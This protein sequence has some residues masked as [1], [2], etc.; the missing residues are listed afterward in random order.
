MK[1][2]SKFST[3][4]ITLMLLLLYLPILVVVL[5]SFNGNTSRTAAIRFSGFSLHWYK[6]LFHPI[7]GYGTQ[8]IT[9]LQVALWSVFISCVIGTL[10]AVSMVK[11]SRRNRQDSKIVKSLKTISEQLSMLPIMIPEIILAIALMALFAKVGFPFGKLTLVLAHV[12]FCI[13]YILITVKSRL[14]TLDPAL[15]EAARD[16]GASP[17][18]AFFTITLPLIMPAIVSGALLAFAMSMDDFVISF[19]V[20]G[21]ETSTL[22]LKIYS[23][24]KVGVT[25]KVNALCTVMLGTVFIAFALAQLL[26]NL[27]EKKRSI[28]QE[29]DL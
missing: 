6:D 3:I 20:N 7:S 4:Y 1:R 27:S 14:A 25:P 17:Q 28:Q 9:S 11:K 23:S 2:K 19:F 21:A 29:V 15:E 22:P 8:L 5:Y 16:L 10:G 18:K 12:T 24:V 13:P 26:S